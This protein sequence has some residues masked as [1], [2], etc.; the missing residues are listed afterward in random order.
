MGNQVAGIPVFWYP[1]AV[2]A[3]FDLA[4]WGWLPMSLENLPN[5]AQN[6]A[7]NGAAFITYGAG[8]N[9]ALYAPGADNWSPQPPAPFWMPAPGIPVG[10]EF[11][12]WSDSSLTSDWPHGG[13]RHADGTWKPLPLIDPAAYGYLGAGLAD[14][15]VYLTWSTG[16]STALALVYRPSANKWTM[17]PAFAPN[18][19]GAPPGDHTS[20]GALVSL[21][22]DSVLLVGGSAWNKMPNWQFMSKGVFR[23]KL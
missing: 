19:P 16:Q 22:D 2:G 8:S 9:N 23:L 6:F 13:L 18:L 21:G 14:R 5:S 3:R 17:V 10:D 1:G 12:V 15:A 20:H 11:V 7:W 4:T